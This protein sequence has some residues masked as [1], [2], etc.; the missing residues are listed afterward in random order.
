M[1]VDV[2]TCRCDKLPRIRLGGNV[3]CAGEGKREREKDNTGIYNLILDPLV[4]PSRFRRSPR[5]QILDVESFSVSVFI[6]DR[7]TIANGSSRDLNLKLSA[8]SSYLISKFT[9]I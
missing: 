9:D 8:A 2:F 7:T 1:A 4:S 6:T 5:Q 3:G